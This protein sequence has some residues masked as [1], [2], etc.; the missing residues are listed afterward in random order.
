M[1]TNDPGFAMMPQAEDAKQGIELPF[2]PV[3][4]PGEETPIAPDQFDPKWETT[5]TEIW[6]YYAYYIGNNG[7][8]L[9]NFGERKS[10]R[11]RA[12]WMR[13]AAS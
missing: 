11:G 1:G 3:V 12:S 13:R 6:A 5:K 4:D 8:T 7:L 9:L 2:A 10:W